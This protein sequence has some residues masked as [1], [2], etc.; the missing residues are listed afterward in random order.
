MLTIPT[1]GQIN[2]IN[3]DN[4]IHIEA[5]SNYSKFYFAGGK[6][7]VVSK[8]LRL[9]NEQLPGTQFLRTHRKHLV[10]KNYI[11]HYE[12]GKITLV[13]LQKIDVSRRKK[14]NVL[15]NWKN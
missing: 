4:I 2:R 3:P 10:N 9:I 13:N 11:S 15:L 1:C 7:L 8:V 12:N 5:I 6:T 14:T